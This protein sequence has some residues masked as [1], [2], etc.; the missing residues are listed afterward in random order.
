MANAFSVRSLSCFHKLL[1]KRSE[2]QNVCLGRRTLLTCESCMDMTL[3]Q[4][5]MSVGPT[6]RAVLSEA[7]PF[8]LSCELPALCF[9]LQDSPVCVRDFASARMGTLFITIVCY[10]GRKE[11]FGCI[12]HTARLQSA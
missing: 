5:T 6:A 7:H 10:S 1:A 12:I 4:A 9:Q 8:P 3:A 2:H 11:G